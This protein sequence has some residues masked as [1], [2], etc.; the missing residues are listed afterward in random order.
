M[1]RPIIIDSAE[2]PGS[3][4]PGAGTGFVLP[5]FAMPVR[6]WEPRPGKFGLQSVAGG[7]VDRLE[8]NG[9]E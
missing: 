8:W 4:I 9:S 3:Q 1:D 5:G 6:I 7:R 2:L